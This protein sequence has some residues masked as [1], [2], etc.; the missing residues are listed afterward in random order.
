M[1][2]GPFTGALL[3]DFGADVVKIEQPGVGDP[4]RR[5]LPHKDDVSLWWKVLARN[6]RSVTLDLHAPKG[7]EL[8]R[9]LARDAD[10]V[11]ES[12]RPGTLERWNVGWDDLH[13]LN[14]ALVM[15]RIS[16][17]GQTGPY[18]SRPGFGRFA[19]AFSGLAG[20]TGHPEGPPLHSGLPLADYITGAMG[21]G[22]V[23]SA[24]LERERQPDG[25]GQQVDLAL[26]E[27]V[28]RM[29][30]FSVP[31]HDLLGVV[32]SR[33]GNL[34][35]YV[36]PVNTYR[37]SDPQ[38][39][40]FTASTPSIVERFF[41]AM[42]RADLLEDPRFS[43]NSARVQHREALDAVVGE[44]FGRHTVSEIEAIFDAHE[45]PFAPVLDVAQI[46]ADPHYAAREDLIEIEDEQLGSL[47]MQAVIPKFGRT[48]G[49]V[50]WAGPELG[51]HNEEVL[52]GELHLSQEE[53]ERLRREGVV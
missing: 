3:A 31:E 26:F 9:A 4:V 48:P 13:A 12:F 28:F 15:L 33:M 11:V 35:P 17:F 21:W 10:V 45:V 51:Q 39:I 18:R 53:I 49:K 7:Q 27:G 1:V 40:T 29:M 41:R 6:K 24:L 2:A 16:G 42:G 19:E 23:V 30:E 8:L 43:T 47:R 5:L 34:N 50:R 44:W 32:R 37:T 14:P 22:A 46:A 36:A 52:G 38:W 25:G 20:I